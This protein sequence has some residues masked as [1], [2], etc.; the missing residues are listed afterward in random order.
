MLSSD[1]HT[2]TGE[3]FAEVISCADGR[4]YLVDMW[5]PWCLSCRSFAPVLEKIAT[6]F[7]FIRKQTSKQRAQ[8]PPRDTTARS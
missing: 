7:G 6:P 2:L 8:W 1:V 4:P 5:A 3:E